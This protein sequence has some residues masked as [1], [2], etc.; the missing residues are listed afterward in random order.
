MIYIVNSAYA[1][2]EHRRAFP[3]RA[4][5]A[6]GM[7]VTEVRK[8]GRHIECRPERNKTETEYYNDAYYAKGMLK[9]T[10]V[11]DRAGKVYARTKNAI[12]AR[13]AYY[14]AEASVR[15]EGKEYGQGT[16]STYGYDAYGN[17]TEVR[18][19]TYYNADIDSILAGVAQRA[20][21]E[22]LR[23]A[24]GYYHNDTPYFHAHPTSI[25][26]WGG[27]GEL[28]RKRKGDYDSTTGALTSLRQY[29]DREHYAEH[30]FGYD[31]Y[32]NTIF[33]Y[34]PGG[35][36]K[37]YRYDKTVHHYPITIARTGSMERLRERN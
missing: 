19:E 13:Y 33:M 28:L 1:G 11:K 31:E 26:V 14:D 8:A 5:A 18:Q 24:I 6:A 36:M 4:E 34:E 10:V 32:G 29:Y 15:Y 35:S 22:G 3:P 23:A 37:W 16:K 27:D 2:L 9:S 21:R 20:E 25:A 12:N 7:R 17:V 30:R